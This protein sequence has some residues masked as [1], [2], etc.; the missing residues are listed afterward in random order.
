MSA[1]VP[2][3][4][5]AVLQARTS[6]SRLPGKVLLPILD[7]PMLARQIER[8]RRCA[9]FDE[10]VV[11]TS[12]DPSDD[13]LAGLCADMRVCCHRGS[14]DDVLD[15]FHGAALAAGADIVVRLTGDCP[16][17]EPTVIDRVVAA[18]RDNGV[19]YASN[20]LPPTYPDGLDVEVFSFAALD[21]AW[22]EARLPSEREH[23]T[24]YLYTHDELFRRINVAADA[25]LSALRWTV[26]NVDDL[27]FVR[28]IYGL[29]YPGNPAFGMQDVLDCLARHPE[30]QDSGRQRNEGYG[31]SLQKDAAVPTSPEK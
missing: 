26:D 16:L 20:V 11:A 21:H 12:S 1:P 14:L 19:D 9:S 29:L 6:S 10:L 30:L 13:H 17:A 2:G 15:R 4:C 3:K 8:L 31:K 7:Q 5:V 25:D 22:R 27:D 23:V 28:R 18:F 24:P